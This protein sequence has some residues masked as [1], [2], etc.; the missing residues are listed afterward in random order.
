MCHESLQANLFI[1]EGGS[2]PLHLTY[3]NV[4]CTGLIICVNQ[5]KVHVIAQCVHPCLDLTLY[6]G[7]HFQNA[8][9]LYPMCI[10]NLVMHIFILPMNMMNTCISR[11]GIRIGWRKY[12]NEYCKS[13]K[14]GWSHRVNICPWQTFYKT[15]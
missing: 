3:Q 13:T 4:L 5:S 2:A 1:G 14:G 11:F 9:F 15:L 12:L 10:P 8:Y 6:T 7:L